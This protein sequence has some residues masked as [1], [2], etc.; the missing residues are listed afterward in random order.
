MLVPR[1]FFNEA[2]VPNPPRRVSADWLL[3]GVFGALALVE[4]A[5]NT[6]MYWRW[7]HVAMVLVLIPTL[8]WRRTHPLRVLTV[9]LA[10]TTVVSI[11]G[12]A[13]Q[14]QV[15]EG[16]YTAAFLLINVYAVFRW[17]SGRHAG[18]ALVLM[19]IVFISHLVIDYGGIAETIGG[20]IVFL[21][22]AELGVIARLNSRNQE[23]TRQG[24]RSA[25]RERIARELHDSVAHHVSAIAIQAQAGRRVAANNPEAVIGTLEAIEEAAA[26]TL[27][28]M[29]SMVG[30]LREGDAELTPQQGMTEISTLAGRKGDIDVVVGSL[31]DG[32]PPT[33]V[34]AALFR[35]AQ[36]SVTNAVRHASDASAVEV[37]VSNG[38]DSYRLTVRN[39][40]RR[41]TESNPSGYGLIGMAERARLLGG[42]L[43]AGPASGGGW[44]VEAELPASGAPS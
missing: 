33:A 7:F 38:G 22:P 6:G 39:D 42:S 32:T 24:I 21:F 35:I 3:V 14:G 44:L 18:I 1:Q 15:A 23:Q 40:G 27:S 9:I 28:D 26:R 30:S 8:L 31:P 19:A 41:V 17:A 25:E 16:P 43:E 20:L 34:G 13:V 12:F 36:E 29:R 11:V 4:G 37:H 2:A 10:V 5:L